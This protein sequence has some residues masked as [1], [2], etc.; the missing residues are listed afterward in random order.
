MAKKKTRNRKV[1][2]ELFWKTLRECGGFYSK[3]AKK[4]QQIT[5]QEFTRQ[6]VYF[7]AKENP[8][9]LRDIREEIVDVSEDVLQMII[10]NPKTDPRLRLDGAKFILKTLGKERGYGDEKEQTNVIVPLF[11]FID[12]SKDKDKT[13]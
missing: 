5:G 1:G 7:R 9:L 10:R 13:T 2:E 6:A 8:D 4:L 12:E 3:T 11:K